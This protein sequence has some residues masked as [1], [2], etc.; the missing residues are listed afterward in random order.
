MTD[1]PAPRPV[2]PP[3]YRDDDPSDE[4]RTPTDPNMRPAW[5]YVGIPISERGPAQPPPVEAPAPVPAAV[6]S[7]L[8]RNPPILDEEVIVDDD[9]VVVPDEIDGQ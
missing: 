2:F 4:D 9:T 3:L 8:Q 1:S 6:L 7:Y 5:T